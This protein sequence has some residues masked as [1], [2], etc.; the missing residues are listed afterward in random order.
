HPRAYLEHAGSAQA[1]QEDRAVGVTELPF[2]FLMNALRLN[3]GFAIG[4]YR[5]RTGLEWSALPAAKTARE[6]GLIVEHEGRVRP[7]E[8]GHRHLNGLLTLFL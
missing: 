8:L 5:A 4:D 6:R 3:D 1:V 7:T 2:E